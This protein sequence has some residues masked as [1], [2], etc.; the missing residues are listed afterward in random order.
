MAELRHI[1]VIIY[2][3]SDPFWG[4]RLIEKVSENILS[5]I[6]NPEEALFQRALS[7]ID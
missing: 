3:M 5:A 7:S 2:K 1:R 6:E 4:Q